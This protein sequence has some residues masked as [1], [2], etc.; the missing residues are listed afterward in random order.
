MKYLRPAKR[1]LAVNIWKRRDELTLVDQ[2]GYIENLLETHE[3]TKRKS[4]ITPMD[5]S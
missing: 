2:T 1:F 3:M 4:F 5:P